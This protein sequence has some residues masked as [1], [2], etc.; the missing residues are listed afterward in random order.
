M[1]HALGVVERA[2][3]RG[4]PTAQPVGTG[5]AD[6]EDVVTPRVRTDVAKAVRFVAVHH[7]A[8]RSAIETGH[9]RG[10]LGRQHPCEQGERP[11]QEG[12]RL[13]VHYEN[14]CCS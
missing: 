8:R 13:A 2:L 12:Q 11:A 1:L 6:G 14:S 4:R 9:H 5:D 3:V 10:R 7:P